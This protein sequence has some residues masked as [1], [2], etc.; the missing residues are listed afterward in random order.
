M[1]L[2]LNFG[3]HPNS[4]H[5]L[6]WQRAWTVIEAGADTAVLVHD[7]DGGDGWPWAYRAEQRFELGEDGLSVTLTLTNTAPTR[8]C[9]QGSASIPISR[10]S[11]ARCCA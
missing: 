5:G 4:L 11:P 2:P 6:G 8:R 10:F 7:H 1:Q 9:R 3:D